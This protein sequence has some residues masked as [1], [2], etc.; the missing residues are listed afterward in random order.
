[1]RWTPGET[2]VRREVLND[3]R[4]WVAVMVYVVEDT[5]DQ[6]VTYLPEGAEFGFLDGRFPTR[7]GRHPWNRGE[8]T[9]WQGHGTL[10]LQRP[11]QDHA[12]W[13]FWEGL[14]R[15]F[16]HWYV[17]IQQAFRRTSIGYDTQDL[18]L[19]IVVPWS[20]PWEFKDRDLM[21]EH[22]QRGRYTAE[23]IVQV[24]ALGDELGDELDAGRRWWDER[25]ASWSPDPS[26]RPVALPPS[27]A[28][29]TTGPGER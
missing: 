28:L 7:T 18:E 19:D 8:G 4:P 15:A 6:L 5:P 26:W 24:L 13:H 22:V 12:L 29:V 16:D 25:W 23:Q 21:S 27:W 17:N 3:G 20:G 14:D 9:C 2:I 1:M 10:M 11:G